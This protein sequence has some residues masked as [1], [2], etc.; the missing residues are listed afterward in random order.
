MPGKSPTRIALA[1]SKKRAAAHARRR[2]K[3]KNGGFWRSKFVPKWRA[4]VDEDGHY[5]FAVA[6]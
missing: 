5:S 2:F 4:A 3:R 1:G 6:L